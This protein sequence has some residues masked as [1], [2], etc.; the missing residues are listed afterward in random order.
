[1]I[2]HSPFQTDP[3]WRDQMFF[4]Y[5]R[6]ETGQ[7]LGAAYQTGRTVLLANLVIRKYQKDIPPWGC[8]DSG[9]QAAW[10]DELA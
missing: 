4:K 6:G 1:M 8:L 9:E 3:A 7:G 10:I 2:R 5:F